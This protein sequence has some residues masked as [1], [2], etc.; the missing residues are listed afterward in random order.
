MNKKGVP[1]LNFLLGLILGLFAVVMGVLFLYRIY[2]NFETNGAYSD[3]YDE[4][5]AKIIRLEDGNSFVMSYK[6][7]KNNFVVGFDKDQREAK[8]VFSGEDVARGSAD[9][10]GIPTTIAM[11]PIFFGGERTKTLIIEKP[12]NCGGGKNA[13]ICRCNDI[14]C[15][16]GETRNCVNLEGIEKVDGPHFI[17]IVTESKVL[18]TD[19]YKTFFIPETEGKSIILNVRKDGKT[20]FINS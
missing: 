8:F 5:R 16:T 4:L 17:G 14:E 20:I 6:P 18:Q 2:G 7:S 10:S 19:E 15:V 9:T 1:S 11:I 3:S 12:P 13:C